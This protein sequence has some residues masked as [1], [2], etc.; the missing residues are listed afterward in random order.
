MHVFWRRRKGSDN[1]CCE[2]LTMHYDG[3]RE[4]KGLI[5]IDNNLTSKYAVYC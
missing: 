3:E 5:A 1:F 4:K 2:L